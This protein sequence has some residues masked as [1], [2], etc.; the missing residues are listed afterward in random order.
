MSPA[1]RNAGH[2]RQDRLLAIKRLYLALLIDAQHQR[3]IGRRQIKTDDVA[4]LVDEQRVAGKLESLRAMRLQTESVPDP[5]DRCVRKAC[6]RR[7]RTDRPMRGV[8][9]RG[10]KRTLDDGGDLIVIDCPRSARTG[11]VQQPFDAVLQKTPTPL[12]DRVLVDANLTRNGL[13]GNAVRASEDN[14]AAFRQ[15]PRHTM[16]TNLSFEIG[17]F[18]CA[19]DQRSNRSSCRTG[20]NR[21]P[22]LNRKLEIIMN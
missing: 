16:T 17:S 6:L 7:H 19:E 22:A 18:F 1:L 20:H 3:P 4:D 12:A 14:A 9:W 15:R 13:A 11:F 21:A 2:H 10:P 5:S 8:L